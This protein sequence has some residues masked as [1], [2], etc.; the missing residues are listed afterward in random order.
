MFSYERLIA[1]PSHRKRHGRERETAERK[2]RKLRV[3]SKCVQCRMSESTLSNE[4]YSLKEILEVTWSRW[5]ST[6]SL[7][8]CGC[9]SDKRRVCVIVCEWVW[10]R[11]DNHQW[12]LCQC[13]PLCVC[14]CDCSRLWLCR[15]VAC[16]VCDLQV[17]YY[18]HKYAM[19]LVT[20]TFIWLLVS[21]L[22]HQERS[23]ELSVKVSMGY[24]P[25]SALGHFYCYSI[26]FCY[27]FDLC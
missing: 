23:Q 25:A 14:V 6:F 18:T 9:C 3:Y 22:L 7:A 2:V 4:L 11:T 26:Y 24:L 21:I 5:R 27:H 10:W 12:Y 1:I 20:L 19:H 16:G 13:V 15:R 8:L 17:R